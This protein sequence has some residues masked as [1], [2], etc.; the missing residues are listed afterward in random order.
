[1]WPGTYAEIIVRLWNTEFV[2]EYVGEFFIVVLTGM[3]E[4][5]FVLC[6]D[7]FRDDERLDELRTG[8]DD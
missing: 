3:N 8:T 7:F 4:Y 6:A 2:E 1:M 5:L